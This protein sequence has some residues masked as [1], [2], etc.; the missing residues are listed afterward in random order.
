[1]QREEVLLAD[2]LCTGDKPST[3]IAGMLMA[4]ALKQGKFAVF[5]QNVLGQVVM[6]PPSV[7]HLDH[8]VLLSDEEL[9][10]YDEDSAL[11]LMIKEGRHED[12]IIGYVERRKSRQASKPEGIL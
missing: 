10:Q 6:L 7:V 3:Y 12:D 2:R 5:T 8:P 1:M 11:A 4:H 9:D